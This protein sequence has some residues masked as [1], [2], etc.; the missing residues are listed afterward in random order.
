MFTVF[1]VSV[2][3]LNLALAVALAREALLEEAA[4]SFQARIAAL[5]NRVLHE[6]MRYRWKNAIRSRLQAQGAPVWIPQDDLANHHKNSVDSHRL[7]SA[8]LRSLPKTIAHT[9][10]THLLPAS[11]QEGTHLYRPRPRQ[12][13]VQGLSQMQLESAAEEAGISVA[14]IPLFA[15][16]QRAPEQ[17][18]TPTIA[19]VPASHR[20]LGEHR[21]W[22]PTFITGA[23]A[24]DR[25]HMTLDDEDSSATA[26]MLE[27]AGG[28][29]A[30]VQ[31]ADSLSRS[32]AQEERSVF[33]ARLALAWILFI[34]FWMV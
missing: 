6:R 25:N 29:L 10:K 2:G 9:L 20:W 32:I 30:V 17:I 3:I 1:Y 4:V 13:N 19:D 23:T 16:P 12:L 34:A 18:R 28:D 15:T 11:R 5:R 33:A 21:S 26:N 14:D 31:D 27:T 22:I 24:P 8:Y 7:T